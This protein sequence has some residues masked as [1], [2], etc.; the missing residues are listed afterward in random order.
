M[1]AFLS[2]C[3]GLCAFPYITTFPAIGW[4][5]QK[6]LLS[7]DTVLV[8]GH[9]LD[10]LSGG[11]IPHELIES[12]NLSI[13]DVV[14]AIIRKHYNMMISGSFGRALRK[15]TLHGRIISRLAVQSVRDIEEA[16]GAYECWEWQERQAKAIV[17]TVRI[18]DFWGCDWWLPFWDAEIMNFW[19]SV[20]FEACLERRFCKH[21][22]EALSRK[23]C[24]TDIPFAGATTGRGFTMRSLW[25]TAKKMLPPPGLKLLRAGRRLLIYAGE[26]WPF[27]L[28][29]KGKLIEKYRNH[30]LALYGI[31]TEE[32]FL[33]YRGWRVLPHAFWIWDKMKAIRLS[34][35]GGED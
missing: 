26:V 14:R 15:A 33:R 31:L 25:N 23:L 19:K 6:G 5:R 30:P 22:V 17:N 10:F 35:S 34:S 13:T 18:Y 1:K 8:P 2:Q 4:L 24:R 21:Y 16:V 20:P 27:V 12:K 9:T 29:R 28:A 32:E 7:N 11:H 3:D